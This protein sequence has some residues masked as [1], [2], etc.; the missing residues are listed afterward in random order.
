MP[1]FEGKL[2]KFLLKINNFGNFQGTPSFGTSSLKLVSS[3][4]T[5]CQ[6]E[7]N[8]LGRMSSNVQ[9]LAPDSGLFSHSWVDPDAGSVG[10]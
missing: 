4:E 9:V 7:R 8:P 1:S 10:C 2:V 5:G 6:E 3:R